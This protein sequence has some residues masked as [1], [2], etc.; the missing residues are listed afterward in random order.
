MINTALEFGRRGNKENELRE[1]FFRLSI[2]FTLSDI[3]FQKR[4]YQ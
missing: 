4:Q 1:N 3:W 2:G